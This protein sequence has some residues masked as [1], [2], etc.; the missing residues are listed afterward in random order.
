MAEDECV[1]GTSADSD[2]LFDVA[3]LRSSQ[4][5]IVLHRISV[6]A[7]IVNIGCFWLLLSFKPEIVVKVCGSSQV[8][9]MSR[10][11]SRCRTNWTDCLYTYFQLKG[12]AD[13]NYDK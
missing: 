3:I 10:R 4:P 6:S 8:S 1:W 11:I 9:A 13:P 2:E 5:S 12:R 7:D